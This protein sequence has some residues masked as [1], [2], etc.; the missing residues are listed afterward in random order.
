MSADGRR[1]LVRGWWVVELCVMA[2]VCVA[3]GGWTEA[4]EPGPLGFRKSADAIPVADESAAEV[5]STREPNEYIWHCTTVDKGTA[6]PIA[7]VRVVWKFERKPPLAEGSERW[8]WKGEFVSN[9]EGRYDV[10]VPKAIVDDAP[11]WV[12]IEYDHPQYLPS[13]NSLWPLRL[14][15]DPQEGLDY[16]HIQLEAGVQVAGRVVLP[17]GSSA[18]GVPL[19]FGS[20]RDGFGDSNGGF[21]HG[22]WTRTDQQGRYQF[23]TRNTWPQRVHWFPDQYENNSK[24]LTKDFGEQETIRLKPGLMLAGSVLDQH[25]Q[26]LAGIVIRATA[27]TR[28]PHLFAT[29]DD[30]GVFRF[31]PLPAGQYSL[32]AVRSYHDNAYWRIR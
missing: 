26:P 30:K 27:G 28:V 19:M 9:E 5:R 32:M 3:C 14:P 24:A 11:R 16:R 13:R 18:P 12:G 10:R 6:V 31:A 23:Y 2:A 8:S 17:D 15:D 22:F 7:N 1:V 29:S 4:R 21:P 25:G 20:N